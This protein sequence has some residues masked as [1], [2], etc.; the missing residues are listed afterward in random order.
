MQV[1]ELI[2]QMLAS[3]TLNEETA[4]DLAR[5]LDE[6]RAGT[7]DP[8][9]AAYVVALNEKLSGTLPDGDGAAGFA[10]I[11]A[12]DQRLDGHTIAEWRDRALAAEAER[13]A[14]REQIAAA[15]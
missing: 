11:P 3:G 1:D 12:A 8:D 15:G 6:Y 5:M 14:L 9:D 2:Q 13:D 10:A 4:A 7:L